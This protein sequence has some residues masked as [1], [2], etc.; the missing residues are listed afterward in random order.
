VIVVSFLFSIRSGVFH[1][2]FLRR[3]AQYF[4]I[5]SDTALRAAADMLRRFRRDPPPA[6]RLP[7]NKSGNARRIAASSR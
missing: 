4:F 3:A 6:D 7:P 5:R 2:L 1:P